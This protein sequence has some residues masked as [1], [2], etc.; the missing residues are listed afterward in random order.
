MAKRP[1]GV[2][3]QKNIHSH[4]TAKR[5]GVKLQMLL[6]KNSR[7][8]KHNRPISLG[9]LKSLKESVIRNLP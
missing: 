3:N 6:L 2:T 1:T 9:K 7:H 4:K 5:L 8:H